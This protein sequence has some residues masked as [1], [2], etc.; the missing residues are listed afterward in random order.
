M[1]S[2]A[3]LLDEHYPAWLAAHLVTRGVDASSVI[4][5]EELRGRSDTEVLTCAKREGRVVVT[6]DINTFPAAIDAVPNH[7]GVI[8]CDSRRFP[9]TASALLRLEDALC[10]F[11]E[12]APEASQYPGFVWWLSEAPAGPPR[13]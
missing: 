6:E 13:R 4:G 5:R 7:A 1:P 2:V 3:L 10:A 11:F 9:R 8:F 12:T